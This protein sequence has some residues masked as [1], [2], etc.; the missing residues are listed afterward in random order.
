MAC[1]IDVGYLLVVPLVFIVRV[2]VVVRG[3]TKSTS[4]VALEKTDGDGSSRRP[5]PTTAGR[6]ENLGAVGIFKAGH[7]GHGLGGG[8]QGGG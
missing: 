8:G 5:E 2:M 6:V 3:M 7:G 4:L 1:P